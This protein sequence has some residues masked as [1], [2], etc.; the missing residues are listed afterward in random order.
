MDISPH[1]GLTE[2][3]VR[4]SFVAYMAGA[5]EDD[6]RAMCSSDGEFKLVM[7]ACYTQEN[8]EKRWQHGVSCERK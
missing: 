3:L 2:D 8:L 6:I 5:G 7:C 4:R 1:D